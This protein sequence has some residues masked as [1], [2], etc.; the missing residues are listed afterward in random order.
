MRRPIKKNPVPGQIALLK[1]MFRTDQLTA[2]RG[3]ILTAV[4]VNIGLAIVV[5]IV[6]IHGG[7]GLAGIAWFATS[8]AVNVLRITPSLVFLRK[9]SNENMSS[10]EWSIEQHLR[11]SWVTALASGVV[12]SFIPILCGGYTAGSSMFYLIVICGATAGAVTNG[13]VYARMAICFI[14]P[15]LLSITGCLLLYGQNFNRDALAATVVLYLAGLIHIA[16]QSEQGFRELSLAKNEATSLATSLKE[17]N[18]RST[19]FG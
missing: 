7:R 6:A 18:Q 15:P 8:T 19:E 4:P 16:R 11:L 1:P 10:I 14:T 12:W 3:R 5:T 2:V 9:R 13:A 17:A